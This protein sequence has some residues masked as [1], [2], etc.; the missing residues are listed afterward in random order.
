VGGVRIRDA[1]ADEAEALTRLA[2]A[3]KAHWG[4]SEAF[5]ARC[6]AELTLTSQRC[7]SGTVRALLAD[8]VATARAHGVTSLRI[9][10]DPHAEAFYAHA[11]A[12]RTGSVPSGSI[13]GRSLPLLTL[14]V[15]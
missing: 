1:R 13:P 15:G 4:Y 11:G 2:L 8:A 10:A 14:A 6:V 5:M 12:V 3:S 9:E 7:A